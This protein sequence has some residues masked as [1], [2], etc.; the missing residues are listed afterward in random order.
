MIN[1]ENK[2]MIQEIIDKT[3]QRKIGWRIGNYCSRNA[4][5]GESDELGLVFFSSSCR[6]GHRYVL[7]II[8]KK[9]EHDKDWLNHLTQK[10][11]E[12]N[13]YFFSFGIS[14]LLNNLNKIVKEET[15]VTRL[16]WFERR[17]W[18]FIFVMIHFI[19]LIGLG[20][21]GLT[22]MPSLLLSDPTGNFFVLMAYVGILVFYIAL[23]C[24]Y[25]ETGN[26]F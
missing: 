5:I 22:L 21:W 2:E 11:I 25:Y 26:F 16:S 12:A 7:R 23:A 9:S 4:Y 15:G 14:K 10:M 24:N 20:F 17:D 6:I 3:E 18:K 8:K 19:I 13:Y 1:R